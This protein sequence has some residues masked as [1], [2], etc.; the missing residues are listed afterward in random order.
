MADPVPLLYWDSNVFLD[1]V[2]ATVKRLPVIDE[3]LHNARN[4]EIAIVTSVVTIAEVAFAAQEK[5]QGLL[6]PEMEQKIGALWVPPSPVQLVEFHTL[7]AEDARALMRSALAHGWSLKPYDAVH[8]AS[9]QRMGVDEVHSY[10]PKWRK[11]SA[12]IRRP[13]AEP[14]VGQ[15]GMFP[16]PTTG[17]G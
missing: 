7:V 11:Y 13:I 17:V 10:E 12:L 1:Y 8:L 15:V 16:P 14:S 4:A 6:S 2:N 5:N 3:L 9:A